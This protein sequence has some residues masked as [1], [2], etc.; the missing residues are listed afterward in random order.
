VGRS[1]RVLLGLALFAGAIVVGLYG[2]FGVLYQGDSG[3]GDT[4]VKMGGRDI[5]GQLVGVSSLILAAGMLL[6]GWLVIRRRSI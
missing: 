4:Y 5:D 6:A 2:L 3:G 1:F